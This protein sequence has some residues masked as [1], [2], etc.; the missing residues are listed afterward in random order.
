MFKVARL[1]THADRRLQVKGRLVLRGVAVRRGSCLGFDEA[2]E[3][4]NVFELRV[5]VE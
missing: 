1:A 3:A 4:R 2:V 5:G